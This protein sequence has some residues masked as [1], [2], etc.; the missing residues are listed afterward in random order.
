M[1]VNLKPRNIK[2]ISVQ[3]KNLI[4]L[5]WRVKVLSLDDHCSYMNAT[6][7]LQKEKPEIFG[8]QQD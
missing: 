3:Y 8:P 1:R 7:K 4:Y 5:N 6:K 2:D